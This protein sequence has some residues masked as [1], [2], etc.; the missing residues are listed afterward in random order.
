MREIW[1]RIKMCIRDRITWIRQITGKVLQYH[2]CIVHDISIQHSRV[3][4]GCD[5][6]CSDGKDVYKRQHL[7]AAGLCFQEGCCLSMLQRQQMI[8]QDPG[9]WVC[10]VICNHGMSR[11]SEEFFYICWILNRTLRHKMEYLHCLLYTSPP[12]STR[13]RRGS[14]KNYIITI[15]KKQVYKK[16]K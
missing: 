7:Y 4:R 9:L 12:F 3:I 1:Y 16:Y 10:P 11:L 13:Y 15:Y 14:T 8:L 5:S 6:L 2:A